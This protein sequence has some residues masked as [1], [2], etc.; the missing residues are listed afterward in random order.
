M[1]NSAKK[2]YRHQDVMRIYDGKLKEQTLFSWGKKEV[3]CPDEPFRGGREKM[4]QYTIKNLVEIGIQIE[5]SNLGLPLEIMQSIMLLTGRNTKSPIL[6]TIL[7]RMKEPEKLDKKG[8][9]TTYKGTIS[10]T[11]DQFVRSIV[12]NSDEREKKEMSTLASQIADFKWLDTVGYQSYF[13]IFYPPIPT[14][15]DPPRQSEGFSYRLVRKEE[16][17]NFLPTV[18]DQVK[19]IIMI[20]IDAIRKKVMLKTGK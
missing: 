4:R 17:Q 16:V 9:A 8:D 15:T 2:T 12:N 7:R 10:D 14:N 3:I 6:Q 1:T 19:G 13:I 5:L 11:F 18:S 20:N